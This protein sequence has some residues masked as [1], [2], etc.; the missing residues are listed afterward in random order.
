[1]KILASLALAGACLVV[2]PAFAGPQGTGLT[3]T[4][5]VAKKNLEKKK[6]AAAKTQVSADCAA[7]SAK[8]DAK[9]DGVSP[10][11]CRAS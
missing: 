5:E 4:E 6:R 2:S 11:T 7:P 1:M 9:P 3:F 10:D 8:A